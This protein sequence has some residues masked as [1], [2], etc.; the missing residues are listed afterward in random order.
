MEMDNSA[1]TNASLSRSLPLERK[2]P[3][4]ILGVLTFVLAV[5]LGISYY[6]IR[7]SALLSA[8]ERLAGLSRVLG[9]MVQAP[10][11]ARLPLMARAA[12]DTAVIAAVLAPDRPPSE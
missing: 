2:L 7:R 5:S 4:L 11:V 12:H 10:I 6:A 8:S 3:L 1:P 9:P